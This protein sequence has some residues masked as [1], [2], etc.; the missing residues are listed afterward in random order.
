MLAFS[1]AYPGVSAKR[2]T[3]STAAVNLRG[4]NTV[5]TGD[6]KNTKAGCE[7]ETTI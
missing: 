7:K 3:A 5:K 1:L 4:V 2:T 6:S